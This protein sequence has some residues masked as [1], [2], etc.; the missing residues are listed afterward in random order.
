M[1]DNYFKLDDKEKSIVNKII[2]MYDEM[3]NLNILINDLNEIDLA[4]DILSKLEEYEKCS[5]FSKYKKI[6]LEDKKSLIQYESKVLNGFE[7]V[8]NISNYINLVQ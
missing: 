1:K 3:I 7:K 4:I 6:V 5:K 8:M 2:E